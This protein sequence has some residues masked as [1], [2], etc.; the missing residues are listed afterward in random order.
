MMKH[1]PPREHPTSTRGGRRTSEKG[2]CQSAG[3]FF[4]QRNRKLRPEYCTEVRNGDDG[5]GAAHEFDNHRL[6]TDLQPPRPPQRRAAV[7]HAAPPLYRSRILE[8]PL[9]L[10]RRD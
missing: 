1:V 3:L 7:S 6:G 10:E 4:V 5:Q 8:Q 9:L 2:S